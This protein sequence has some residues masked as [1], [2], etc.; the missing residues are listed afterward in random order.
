MVNIRQIIDGDT[1]TLNA[2]SLLLIDSVEGGASVGFLS[3]L[4]QEMAEQYWQGMLASLGEALVL[5]I[6]EEAGLIVGSVQLALCTKENGRHRAEVQKL[7]VL[8]THRGRGIAS[9][10]LN[11]LEDFALQ[12]G[13]TLLVLDTQAGSPAEKVYQHFHWTRLGEI[14]SYAL[15]PDGT[16]HPTAYYYK[17]IGTE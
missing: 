13:R 10:L 16:L 17:Q 3:P 11:T 8:S 6:A 9:Q 5:W 1:N 15:S 7:F 2:L 14:P 4:K 12:A